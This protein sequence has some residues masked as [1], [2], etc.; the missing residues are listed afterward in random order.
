MESIINNT[1][2]FCDRNHS[3]TVVAVNAACR[4]ITAGSAAVAITKTDLC[5]P[6]S[7]R[8]CRIKSP[9]SRPRSPINAITITSALLYLAIIPSKVLFPTPLPEKIPMRCPF[10]IGVNTSIALTPVIKGSV[11]GSLDKGLMRTPWEFK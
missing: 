1:F 9:T 7:P 8:F 10:P 11:I 2:L 5:N 3:A 6:F 4:R